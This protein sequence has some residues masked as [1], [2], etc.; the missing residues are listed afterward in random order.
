MTKHTKHLFIVYDERAHA[1]AE[2]DDCAVLVTEFS[3]RTAKRFGARG[4][5][6]RYDIDTDGKTL[7]NETYIGPTFQMER[8]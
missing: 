7:I 6:W 4:Y 8:G 2:T 1:G 5:V 3:E